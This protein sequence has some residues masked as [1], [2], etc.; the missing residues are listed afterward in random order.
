MDRILQDLE[1]ELKQ[2]QK[3]KESFFGETVTTYKD[4]ARAAGVCTRALY[5]Y[6][7][8]FEDFP[9]LPCFAITVRG[10]MAKHK[11]PRQGGPRPFPIRKEIAKLREQGLG[12]SKI[13][14]MLGKNPLYI[15]QHWLL[16]QKN[17]NPTPPMGYRELG[18][19]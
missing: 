15:R 19:R 1:A 11:L 18:I 4:A 7:K 10:W 9:D 16:H 5:R 6:R 8:V 3:A 17:P 2:L 13:G 12:Y 14:R